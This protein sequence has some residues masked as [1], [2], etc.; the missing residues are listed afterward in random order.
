MTPSSPFKV[1]S[2]LTNPSPIGNTRHNSL[3]K[4]ALAHSSII[5][6]YNNYIINTILLITK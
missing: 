2:E 3:K 6:N 4:Q 5:G 1:T